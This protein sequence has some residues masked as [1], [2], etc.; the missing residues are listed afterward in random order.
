MILAYGH[1]DAL[2]PLHRAAAGG[3]RAALIQLLDAGTAVDTCGDLVPPTYLQFPPE[4]AESF[5]ASVRARYAVLQ[6]LTPLMVAAGTPGSSLEVVQVLLDRGADARARSGGGVDALWYAASIGDAARIAVLLAA[7]ADADAVAADGRSVVAMAASSADPAGL[8]LLLHAGASPHPPGGLTGYADA[9]NETAPL[10][11]A[12]TA[13]SADSVR[14]LLTLGAAAAAAVSD[15][16]TA[17]M[18]AG[19]PEIV[20]L[21]LAAG[22]PRDARNAFDSNALDTALAQGRAAVATALLDAGCDPNAPHADGRSP[23]LVYCGQPIVDLALLALLL[24]R[25]ADV[26][27]CDAQGQTALHVAAGTPYYPPQLGDAARLLVDAGV[28]VDA[29]DAAGRTPLQL[30]VAKER[31]HRQVIL[32]L[33]QLGADVEARDADGLTPLLHAAGLARDGQVVIPHL[34]AA[35]AD[36]GARTPDGQTA[37]EVAAAEVVRRAQ[38]AATAT[39]DKRP[40]QEARA[41]SEAAQRRQRVRE[42]RVTCRLLEAAAGQAPG[43]AMEAPPRLPEPVW[44]GYQRRWRREPPDDV[45]PLLG[46]QLLEDVCTVAHASYTY[47]ANAAACFPTAAIAGEAF[48]EFDEPEPPEL[49]VY[50][51]YP[52][53][54]D[55]SGTPRAIGPDVLLGPGHAPP[56]VPDLA[57][58]RLLGYDVTECVLDRSWG[59]WNGCSPHSPYC[60]GSELGLSPLV[61]RQCLYDDLAAAYD[62]AVVVGVEQ[63]EPGPYLIIEV[64]R[65]QTP[66]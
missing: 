56:E 9:T 24:E 62:A 49:M 22:C 64:W 19:A 52:L 58:Y 25:G 40:K 27:G 23:L 51:A 60:N 8:R 32:E 43:D 37:R 35:G 46:T 50:C 30:A 16:S 47:D 15:G 59:G 2:P 66:T 44:L 26:H 11:V 31:G 33:L 18:H 45:R 61:N 13:G 41:L 57:D 10:L 34:L 14:L 5:V 7:G 39:S 21:L 20:A 17:L 4:A 65:R 48:T 29:R 6:G 3:D 1:Y 12:A 38:L 55:T 28:P 63:P 36:L 42:A 53:V 54:F